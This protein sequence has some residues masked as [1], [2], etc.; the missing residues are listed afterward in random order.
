MI[1]SN[2]CL[3]NFYN[4]PLIFVLLEEVEKRPQECKNFTEESYFRNLVWSFKFFC[5][6]SEWN[7]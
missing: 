6:F 3:I 5:E 7:I 4:K 1:K 2:N